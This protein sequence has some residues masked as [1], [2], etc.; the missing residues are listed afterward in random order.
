[1]IAATYADF[2]RLLPRDV[3]PS[4][5]GAT[6]VLEQLAATGSEIGSRNV[7][8]YLDL[9]VVDALKREEYFTQLEKTYGVKP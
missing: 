3:A 4:I 7:S 8:D 6:N 2:K 1:V 5:E 9:S